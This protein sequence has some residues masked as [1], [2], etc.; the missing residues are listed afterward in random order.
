HLKAIVPMY[1]TDDRYTDDCHYT[2]GGN[3]RMYYDVG[4]YGG[5]MVAM[6]ALPP[7]EEY[8]GERWAELWKKRL[9]EN[10]P[11]LLKWMKHQTDGPYW[12]GASL[13]PDYDRIKCPVFLIG[14]WRDGYANT[15][16]RTYT[17][18]KVPKKLLMGPWVH[19]RPNTSVPG[20]R[21]NYLNEV[22][23]FFAEHLNGDETGIMKEPPVTVYMQDYAR[24][25]RTL[26]VTPGHWR[27][28]SQFPAAGTKDLELHLGEGGR[29]G[30]GPGPAARPQAAF[31][32]FEYNPTVG[33]TNGY[34]SAGGMTFYLA[35]DQ[36]ADEA[37]SLLWTT[38]PFDQD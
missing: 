22:V 1:A 20:P 15:M 16:L 4:T 6:N 7:I 10:E 12:R 33:L 38:P 32:E 25:E 11:Y 23:R 37:Y 8:V 3:M 2:P 21:I 28:E 9:E 18:L 36:R 34:W 13:R 35:E 19:Q 29:L 24:P 17:K 14:G 30:L 5:T 27:N 31:D 26:D